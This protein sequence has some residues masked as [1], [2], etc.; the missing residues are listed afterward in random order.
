MWRWDGDSFLSSNQ[1]AATAAC[2]HT[3]A[4]ECV[5]TF[6]NRTRIKLW[7]WGHSH[8]GCASVCSMNSECLSSPSSGPALP[9]RLILQPRPAS[10]PVSS[11]RM[12]FGAVASQWEGLR[13]S[14]FLSG[15]TD[16]PTS[17]KIHMSVALSLCDSH[18]WVKWKQWD[19]YLPLK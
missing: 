12:V 2:E 4:S 11:C 9:D 7:T 13:Q 6:N 18:S 3:F 1:R 10:Q 15:V 5:F 14:R 16:F 8:W 19:L 17:E